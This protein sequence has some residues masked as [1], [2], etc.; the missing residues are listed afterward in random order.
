M[1][2]KKVIQVV[3]FATVFMGL[4]IVA[5]LFRAVLFPLLP[6]N[7]SE[8]AAWVGAFGSV[9][10]VFAAIWIMDH[11]HRVS[12]KR[13]F[14]ERA[15]AAQK[16]MIEKRERI[17]ICLM[18]AAHTATG[19]ISS[20]EVLDKARDEDLHWTLANQAKF[21]DRAS[22]PTLQIPMHELGA[23]E[24]VHQIYIISNLAQRLADCISIWSY[25]S[26]NSV[27]YVADLRETV[28]LL[29]PEAEKA[30]TSLTQFIDDLKNKN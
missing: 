24:L 25:R 23:V 9:G 6:G 16:E 20:L 12:E 29:K 15:H 2:R 3:L 14:D 18:V 8:V 4:G 27:T 22:E 19:I 28:A 5:Y 10:A 26:Q 30:F 13:I 11:Q 17:A 1:N 7:N 21:I